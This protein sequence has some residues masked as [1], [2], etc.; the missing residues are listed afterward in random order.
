MRTTSYDQMV[1]MDPDV[2]GVAIARHHHHH[3]KKQMF[4]LLDKMAWAKHYLMISHRSRTNVLELL[5]MN[6]LLHW[7]VTYCN[8]KY[9]FS[10]HSSSQTKR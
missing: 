10:T 1:R 9:V 7:R 4:Y 6:T 5:C 2:T 3:Q 8:S